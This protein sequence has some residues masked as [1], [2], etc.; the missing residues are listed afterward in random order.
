MDDG[1][2]LET[3][4]KKAEL[5]EIVEREYAAF[6]A[7]MLGKTKEEIF[8]DDLKIFFYNEVRG[9]LNDTD[10]TDGDYETLLKDGET[11]LFFLW[12]SP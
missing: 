12:P 9:Y 1:Y 2:F 5:L 11:G 7:D 3:P 8:S 6:R 4:P 10:L